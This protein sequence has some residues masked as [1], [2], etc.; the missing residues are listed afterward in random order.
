MNLYHDIRWTSPK[1][2]QRLDLI[3]PLVYRQRD[4][5]P[6]FYYRRLAG[7]LHAPFGERRVGEDEWQKIAWDQIWGG[8]DQNFVLRSYFRAPPDWG[9]N[10]HIALYLPIGIAKD[11]SHPEALIY[12]DG[13]SYA[14][15]DRHHQ[16]ILL[17]SRWCD[18]QEHVLELHGWTGGT[19]DLRFDYTGEPQQT[20][21]V[22]LVMR[23][24]QLVCIDQPTR[25]FS[26]LARVALAVADAI[27]EQNP[28]RA[29]IFNSLDQ[30]FK[31]LDTREPFSDPF[32]ESVPAA[33]AVLEQGL[34]RCGPPLDV[35]VTTVGHAHIDV[36][37]L[38][39]LGQTRRK[40]GRT[41][42]TT[43]RLMEQYPGYRF[44]QSQPQLYD[45]LRQDYPALFDDIKERVSEGQW[46]VIG[47]MWVEADC[48]LSGGESLA[49]Q[50]LL[51]RTFFRQHFGEGAESP[52]LW[53]PDVF[54]YAWN[55]PQLIKEAGLEYFFTIKIG[56]SQYNR[57]PYDSF[58]WQGLD[59]TRVL[60]HFSPTKDS[61]SAFAS[62]YNAEATPEQVLSTWTNFQQKDAG[63]PGTTP[64]L[65]MVYGHGDG[66]GGPTGEMLENIEH[67]NNFPGAPR[68]HFGTVAQFFERLEQEAGNRLPTWN[69]ELYLEYHRGTYT[70]QARN[71]RANRKC[72]LLLHDAEFLAS[73][74]AVISEQRSEVGEQRS[75]VGEQKSEV[76][77]H[78]SDHEEHHA[79]RSLVLSETDGTQH[80]PRPYLYPTETLHHA[81]QLLCLNQFHDIIP[82]SSIGAVYVESL[83]QYD[84]ITALAEGVKGGALQV[85]ARA[86]G[87][88]LVV[89]NPT[90]FARHDLAFWPDPTGVYE[91][92]QRVDGGGVRVQEVDGGVLL[93]IGD[94]APYSTLALVPA[95]ASNVADDKLL[96]STLHVSSQRLENEF[97]RVDFDEAGDI[98]VLFD[99]ENGRELI[100]PGHVANQFQL[101]EDRPKTPD[102]WEIDIYYDD[103]MWLA[104]RAE[105][106]RVLENG[107]LRGAL[108]VSRCIGN[109]VFTQRIS[110]AH[111]SRRIDFE[112][113]VDWQERHMMLKVAFPVDVLS[114]MATYEI[115]WGNVERP[116]HRNTSWD[117]ARFETCAQKWADLSEGGYGV[118]L[119]NDCKYGYDIHENVIRLTLL[120]SPTDPD[121]NADRGEHQFTY[122]LFPHAGSWDEL[123]ISEAYALNDPLIVW[124]DPGQALGRIDSEVAASAFVSVDQAN[125]IIETIKQAEDGE[126][127]ILRVYECRRK[128][129]DFRLT[130][131]FP[132]ASVWRTNLLEENQKELPCTD[133][134][135][136]IPIKPYQIL[137]L[138]L[139]PGK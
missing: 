41:F 29:H 71:K 133:N 137:T 50:F 129:C 62:T 87:S 139:L 22:P 74:A 57:L 76:G 124:E 39:T 40:A 9:E 72:E 136:S 8:V 94:L 36:A 134:A 37:W 111:N 116:T 27:S 112:T 24:C 110:L 17:D 47:G 114:P 98:T 32:Y 121:P 118:S 73:Y 101:F 125:V 53:L 70:T 135:L 59:G 12:I 13:E 64:P 5:L 108:Q 68:T 31:V 103:V 89:A 10:S 38:W 130:T 51:G 106:V 67:L 6:E 138:R 14:A 126:G 102:A 86:C 63:T 115:Q 52:V 99:K 23:P 123:T 43:L 122:S 91:R 83:E 117:W 79:T 66:G 44:V 46:E 49:R 25:E 15:C 84:E 33:M 100:P 128:R 131:A 107:P 82:G 42:H 60:T 109:S 2:H 90:S 81:W 120:R 48:N 16:E 1:L 45:Y 127:L 11:F 26:A 113:V 65:L 54:G 75:E 104:E 61:D 7:P 105:S 95:T 3:R 80:E 55:L 21:P 18:G 97:L 85:I 132:L 19:A 96:S 35:D 93:D 88:N 78:A 20:A 119:L 56:W 34:D 30:A 77:S 28:T 58:W 92:L 69:G 4:R